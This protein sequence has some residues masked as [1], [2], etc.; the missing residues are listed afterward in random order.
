MYQRSKQAHSLPPSSP[1]SA[2]SKSC[3]THPSCS[4]SISSESCGL[5]PDLT[6]GEHQ[7]ES[8]SHHSI[9]SSSD[10]DCF[11]NSNYFLSMRNIMSG[12][13]II[14]CHP[15]HKIAPIFGDGVIT[16]SMFLDWENACDD[17]FEAAKDPILDVFEVTGGLHHSRINA[18]I[19]NDK[20]RLH[21]LTF[22]VF[23]AKLQDVFLLTDWNQEVLQKILNSRMTLDSLFFNC[24]TIWLRTY[25]KSWKNC[26]SSWQ[27]W[28]CFH[29]RSGWMQWQKQIC[30]W[31]RLQDVDAIALHCTWDLLMDIA[32]H[33]FTGNCCQ[34][35]SN[36]TW[37]S[38]GVIF[39]LGINVVLPACS[40][41]SS[42][43]FSTRLPILVKI[44]L[45]PLQTPSLGLRFLRIITS[46]HGNTH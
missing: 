29:Y 17:F 31:L 30:T 25:V 27:P 42:C 28:I 45:V 44:A 32:K 19:C 40:P 46:N 33:T 3:T 4:L 34:E 6:C 43:T 38:D 11:Q 26:Q 8:I 21:G 39:S 14:T 36:G 9:S 2:S 10:S 7:P 24:S 1:V 18:F 12:N 22:E 13:A 23:M 37:V 5:I 41:V 15:A 35:N 20:P 16:A